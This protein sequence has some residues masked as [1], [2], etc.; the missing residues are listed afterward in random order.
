MIKTTVLLLLLVKTHSCFTSEPKIQRKF[1]LHRKYFLFHFKRAVCHTRQILF[2]LDSININHTFK[3]VYLHIIVIHLNAFYA[4][5]YSLPYFVLCYAHFLK[6]ATNDA[7]RIR[8]LHCPVSRGI[9]VVPSAS[10]I[11]GQSFDIFIRHRDPPL[12][13]AASLFGP[14]SIRLYH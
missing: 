9:M 5:I 2:Q 1:D 8:S 7:T 11:P 14:T 10:D 13:A 3:I 12:G 6:S 4:K